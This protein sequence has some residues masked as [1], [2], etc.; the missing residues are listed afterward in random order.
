MTRRPIAGTLL[1]AALFA[2]GCAHKQPATQPVDPADRATRDPG[3][4]SPDWSDTNISSHD[5]DTQRM[6]RKGLR[7]DLDNVFMP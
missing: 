4:Y 1:C 5:S 2:A 6:D 3:T 7:R